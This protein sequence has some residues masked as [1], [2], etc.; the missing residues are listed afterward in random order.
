MILIMLAFVYEVGD[1][2]TSLWANTEV[3]LTMLLIPL[4]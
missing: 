1:C 2:K 3:K 4:Q